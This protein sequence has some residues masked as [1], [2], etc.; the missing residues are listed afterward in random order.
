[1]ASESEEV[2]ILKKKV[3]VDDDPIGIWDPP[4]PEW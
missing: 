2:R 4:H 3:N 1:L